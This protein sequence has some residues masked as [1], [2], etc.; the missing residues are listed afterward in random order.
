MQ[1]WIIY[2]WIIAV[3]VVFSALGRIYL[4]FRTDEVKFYDLVESV[5][6]LVAIAGLHGYVYQSAYLSPFFWQ[7]VWTLLLVTWLASLRGRKNRE[8][9]RKIGVKK[10]VAVIAATTIIGFPTLVGLF[11]YGFLSNSLWN[12]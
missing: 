10:G 9:I 11:A 4:Y 6:S 7:I 1:F 5:I 3:L 8:M 12:N 2:F